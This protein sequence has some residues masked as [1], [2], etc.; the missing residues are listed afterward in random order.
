LH[1]APAILISG[2]APFSL[3]A[4]LVAALRQR[5]PHSPI[6]G[7]DRHACPIFEGL[8]NAKYLQ[9][10]LNPL[11]YPRYENLGE[12]L[13]SSLRISQH[14]LGFMGIGVLV[15]TAGSYDYG[16]LEEMS[17]KARKRL[18]GTNV[19]GK[20]ELIHSV[21]ELNQSLGYKNS[22]ELTLVDIGSVH[23]LQAAENRSLYGSTKAMGLELCASLHV[24]GELKRAV[25][26]APGAVD[27]HML[28]RNHW[29]AKERGPADF[30]DTLK[31]EAAGIYENVFVS[32]DDIIFG[33]HVTAKRL[34]EAGLREIFE[35]YK[36]RR[37]QQFLHKNGVLTATTAAA[38]LV[39][40]LDHEDSHGIY[41]LTNPNGEMKM[42]HLTFS[43]VSRAQWFD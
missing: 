23:G 24:G 17:A 31:A 4:A 12:E 19:C 26:V 14:D 39:K 13:A 32:C 43:E 6:V 22:E 34:D 16:P 11:S 38:T 7:V 42:R 29:V 1:K 27:T 25:H 41:V 9:L 5:H 37:R 33:E 35:R 28:H 20:I 3:G 2:A 30:I 40:I 21:L 8:G 18:V 15:L 10:D 36:K